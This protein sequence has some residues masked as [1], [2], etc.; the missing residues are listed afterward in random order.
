MKLYQNETSRVKSLVVCLNVFL[1][2]RLYLKILSQNI[3]YYE[4]YSSIWS[5]SMFDASSANALQIKQDKN[6]YNIMVINVGAGQNFPPCQCDISTTRPYRIRWTLSLF[7]SSLPALLLLLWL[8]SFF[9]L[10]LFF[11]KSY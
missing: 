9:L 7:T 3:Y 8:K 2:R 10:L 4:Y 11:I 1:Q 6:S 5:W